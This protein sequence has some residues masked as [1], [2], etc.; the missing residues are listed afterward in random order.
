M[1]KEPK[2]KKCSNCCRAPQPIKEFVNAKGRECSTCNKCRE[3]GKRNDNKPDRREYHNDL[4]KEKKYSEEWRKKQLQERPQEYREHNNKVAKEWKSNN[5]EYVAVWSRTHTN[6]R[7][8]ALK[9]SA[10]K[11]G[12]EW[13]LTDDEAKTM[14]TSPCIY[15]EHINLEERVNGIDRLDSDKPYTAENCRPCCK[16]C[17]YMKGTFDPRTFIEQAKKIASCQVVFP[18]APVCKEH[19]KVNRKKIP[20]QE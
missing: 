18:D 13:L 5:P 17:N 11:R 19:K 10:E 15:C 4:N 14:L 8:N 2:T 20:S 6:A 7:L 12:I 1:E 16:N 3:K 9:H